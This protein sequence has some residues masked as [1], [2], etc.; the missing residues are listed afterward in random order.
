MTIDR[1]WVEDALVDLLRVDTQVPL[2]E[3][4][5]LPGDPKIVT[6]VDEIVM[7]Y[8]EELQPEEIRRHDMGDVAVR[9]GPDRDDGLLIETYIV[10]QHANL[11]EDPNAG[12]VVDGKP[13]GI[14]GRCAV[15]QGA[16][17]NK[18][19][20]ASAFAGMRTLARGL[21]RPV[22]LAINTEGK[23]SH[24]GSR[25]ILDDLGLRARN[26]IVAFGTDLRVSLGNRG[27]VDIQVTVPGRSSHS[28][29]PWL[30]LNPIE[31]A[32]DVIRAL[33]SLPVPDEHP[34]LGPVTVTPYQLRCFPVAPHTIPERAVIVIDRRL[35][36]G[37]NP[38][39]AV[40]ALHSHMNKEGVGEVDIAEGVSM[41]PATV[42]LDSDVVHHL[43][44]GLTKQGRV[45]QTFWSL[46]A[47]DAGYACSIGIPTPMFGPGKR[48]FKGEGLV[49]TDAVSI[50]DCEA[51]AGAIAHAATA[52]CS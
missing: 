2:G 23:S 40:D 1:A 36:P 18:G 41:L 42:S 33:R 47:F 44:E 4:E 37:E 39:T 12:L 5:V 34:D 27:R 46:N 13:Y 10:S 51:A 8:L 17:Q 9:F 30:G 3:T 16:T 43:L 6:A 24:D 21:K 25:R 22:W 48:S 19:P 20:M 50:D 38:A 14:R 31:G 45:A 26:G 7:P 52:L 49:G 35:L 15:G 32:A 11:M 28:S 29:Q